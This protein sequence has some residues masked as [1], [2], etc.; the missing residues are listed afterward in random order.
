MGAE[1]ITVA[2]HLKTLTVRSTAVVNRRRPYQTVMSGNTTVTVSV[3]YVLPSITTYLQRPYYGC[4]TASDV[5]IRFVTYFWT[6]SGR[7]QKM[8]S[9]HFLMTVSG[10]LR[11]VLWFVIRLT[12]AVVRLTTALLRI[13]YVLVWP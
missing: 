2:G 13:Y 11:F 10:L 3:Y 9:A 8:N 6:G 1:V 4:T 12:T 7:Q 5:L